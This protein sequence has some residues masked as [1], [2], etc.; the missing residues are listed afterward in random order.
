M[1]GVTEISE[2]TVVSDSLLLPTELVVCF[3]LLGYI[4]L[5]GSYLPH[6]QDDLSKIPEKVQP[7]T[8]SHITS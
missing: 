8:Y 4:P 6:V 2:I 3:L 1:N 5:E 7:E